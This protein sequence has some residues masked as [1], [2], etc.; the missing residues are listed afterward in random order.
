MYLKQYNQ[1]KNVPNNY[2]P[3]VYKKENRN[4]V[5]YFNNLK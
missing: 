5:K 3:T 2:A 4:I 1:N